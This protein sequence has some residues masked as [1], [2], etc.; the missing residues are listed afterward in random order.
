MNASQ[1]KLN[2]MVELLREWQDVAV[3]VSGGV[4]SMLLAYIAHQVAG[5]NANVYHAFSPAVPKESLQRIRHYAERYQWNLHI[6]DA[7]ELSNN[8]YVSNPV[9]RCYYCKSNLYQRIQSLTD[10]TIVSGTNQ[11]IWVTTDRA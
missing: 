4:D 10:K 11:M 6:I 2:N 7:E 1:Q 3:A 8:S 5:I 9:N